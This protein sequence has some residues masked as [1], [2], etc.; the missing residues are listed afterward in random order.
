MK[1]SRLTLLLA[2]VLSGCFSPSPGGIQGVWQSQQDFD[3]PSTFVT[4]TI[5]FVFNGNE[6][7]R[8]LEQDIRSKQT[9]SSVVLRSKQKG[10]FNVSPDVPPSSSSRMSVTNIEDIEYPSDSAFSIAGAIL[11]NTAIDQQIFFGETINSTFKSRALFARDADGL[12]IKFS[13]GDFPVTLAPPF[14]IELRKVF[15]LFP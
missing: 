13:S 5:E 1:I 6:V 10:V 2:V 8:I 9:G 12:R 11:G 3:A 14:L 15:R 7:V 4:E